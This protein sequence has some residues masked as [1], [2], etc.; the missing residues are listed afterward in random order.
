MRDSRE[1]AD[2]DPSAATMGGTEKEA[3]ALGFKIADAASCEDHK[4]RPRAA[5]SRRRK[6]LGDCSGWLR[7][8]FRNTTI[9]KV[10][11]G[12][13]NARPTKKAK[14]PGQSGRFS[15]CIRLKGEN[16]L[17][18]RNI[19]GINVAFSGC[20]KL[21]RACQKLAAP[22]FR[23]SANPGFAVAQWRVPK[24]PVDQIKNGRRFP[25]YVAFG[26]V[27]RP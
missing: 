15:C 23:L 8:R 20:K 11:M 17:I 7:Q 1:K 10:L 5:A 21:Q 6:R 3:G 4:R 22:I 2:L 26:I 16:P 13:L 19:N 12:R 14:P 25:I 27:D 9:C 24:E 18:L